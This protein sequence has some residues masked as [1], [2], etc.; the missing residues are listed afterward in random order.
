[1][2]RKRAWAVVTHLGWALTTVGVVGF[3]LQAWAL[4]AGL[5]CLSWA[6]GLAFV[7]VVEASEAAASPRKKAEG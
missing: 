1:M 5:L 3:D 7:L 2:S 4:S 6:G